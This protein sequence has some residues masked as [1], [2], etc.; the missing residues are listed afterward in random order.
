MKNYDLH[1]RISN[2][3]LCMNLIPVGCTSY[4]NDIVIFLFIIILDVIK[5]L[6]FYVDWHT[7]CG[8]CSTVLVHSGTPPVSFLL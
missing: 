2:T 4:D 1:T 3:A 7:V 5:A 6:V 8:L